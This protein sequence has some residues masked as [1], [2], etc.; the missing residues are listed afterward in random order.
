MDVSVHLPDVVEVTV[1]HLLLG[2]QLLHLVEQHVHLELGAQVLQAA[3]AEGFDGPIDDQSHQE[4]HV[5][6]EL[7]QVWVGQ[8]QLRALVSEVLLGVDVHHAV[9]HLQP[10]AQVGRHALGVPLLVGVLLRKR[11]VHGSIGSHGGL[12]HLLVA[13][14]LQGLL[15]ELLQEAGGGL[16]E[17]LQGQPHVLL[18]Q[19]QRLHHALGRVQQVGEGHP[20]LLLPR[21]GDALELALQ[22]RLAVLGDV[23]HAVLVLLLK[24]L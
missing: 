5:G 4:I 23:I 7:L 13:A 6:D 19:E 12:G 20:T 9:H 2:C 14:G 16:A 11:G 8:V 18:T 10:K 3:V 24:E 22:Q 15:G 1:G 21:D 17:A